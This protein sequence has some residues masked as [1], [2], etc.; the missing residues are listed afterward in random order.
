MR[1]KITSL[2][3]LSAM[4]TACGDATDQSSG[5]DGDPTPNGVSVD[6]VLAPGTR[7]L[8]ATEAQGLRSIDEVR[9]EAPTA[10]GLTSGQTLLTAER[11]YVLGDRTAASGPG[12]DAFSV[13]PPRLAEIYQSLKLN[14]RATSGSASATFDDRMQRLSMSRRLGL[15]PCVLKND[16]AGLSGYSCSF[17]F[18]SDAYPVVKLD[19]SVGAAADLEFR[20]WD[21]ITNTGSGSLRLGFAGE[22]AYKLKNE[23][24]AHSLENDVCSSDRAQVAG[25]RVRLGTIRIPTNLPGVSVNIPICLAF[26]AKFGVEGTILQL[27]ES[28][29]IDIEVGNNSPPRLRSSPAF[30][31]SSPQ[32]ATEQQWRV[33]ADDQARL[34]TAL[35]GIQAEANLAIEVSLEIQALGVSAVG[36]SNAF[37]G[38]VE[39]GGTVTP[40]TLSLLSSLNS[41]RAAPEYCLTIA[42]LAKYELTAYASVPALRFFQDGN[43][44]TTRKI[45]ELE[46]W[47]SSAPLGTCDTRVDSS[48]SA[49][50]FPTSGTAAQLVA[51][52]TKSDPTALRLWDDKIATGVVEFLDENGV[53]L[54]SATV[55]T[56]TGEA[57]CIRDFGTPERAVTVSA[58]YLGDS[59]FN[60]SGSSF[61]HN[62]VRSESARLIVEATDAALSAS[63]SVDFELGTTAASTISTGGITFRGPLSIA[64][65]SFAGW[66]NPG[67]ALQTRDVAVNGVAN[68]ANYAGTFSVEF[69]ASCASAFAMDWLSNEVSDFQVRMLDEAGNQIGSLI[70]AKTVFPYVSYY[71]A[72]LPRMK[73]VIFTTSG[74]EWLL[75]DNFRYVPGPCQ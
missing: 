18:E 15:N 39:V 28:T 13:R 5:A 22:V 8:S 34:S 1:V 70:F 6:V 60:R 23:N 43:P 51:T 35:V 26:D 62:V 69:D 61:S 41:I 63:T 68:S 31:A 52:V 71:G 44:V 66:P 30:S 9:I 17:E 40:A 67:S 47:R 74:P 48:V 59:F 64:P 16:I 12:F 46:I 29:L 27:K 19:G 4:A 36:L 45:A 75:I 72:Q 7:V 20:G 33:F 55:S 10:L 57:R 50:S 65:Y 37:S 14:G 73:R 42:A 24:R 11:A 49:R 25:G 2:L 38:G 54:C 21:A 56:S 3:L 58:R 53:R 32:P